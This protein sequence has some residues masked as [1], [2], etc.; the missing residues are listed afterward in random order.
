M[1]D[2]GGPLEPVAELRRAAESGYWTPLAVLGLGLVSILLLLTSNWLQERLV[3]QNSDR[4]RIV[5]DIQT[6]IATTHLWIEE[7]VTGDAVDM[8]GVLASF[9]R[10]VGSA[11]MLIAGGSLGEEARIAPLDDPRLRTLAQDLERRLEGFSRLTSARRDGYVRGESVGIG[12]AVDREYDRTF[13][14]VAGVAQELADGLHHHLAAQQRRLRLLANGIM[15]GWGLMVLLAALGLAS[16]ERRRRLTEEALRKSEER[17]LQAQKMEAVGRLAGGIAH[18]INNYLAAI[19]GQAELVKMKAEPGS[20]VA[21]KMDAVIT[22][23]FR[24]SDLI[25]RLLAFSRRQAVQPQ[26][27][28]LNEIVGGLERMMQQLIGEDI[29][30]ATCLSLDLWRVRV[31]PTQVEQVIVN[32]L[33]NAREAMPTGGKVTI[34]TGNVTKRR[35]DRVEGLPPAGDFVLL[36]VTDDGPGIPQAIR[37][38]IFEP[39]FTTKGDSGSS[40]LGLATV[41][42]I[43]EQAGGHLWVYSETGRG[44]TFKIYLPRCHE[45][46][47]ELAAAVREQ[48]AARGTESLLLVEDHLDLRHSIKEVLHELGYQVTTAVDGE[49]A[50]FRLARAGEGE[51]PF[52]LVVTDVVMP[53]LSGRDLRDRLHREWPEVPVLFVSGYT[54]NVVLRHGILAGEV[55]FLQKPF[56]AEQLAQKIR[57]VLARKAEA[58]AVPG[59]IR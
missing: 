22:T 57:E 34:E 54:D 14:E 38:K 15:V 16:K 37:N 36:T 48:A 45:A 49:D 58:V 27:M 2:H 18:D 51:R 33:V 17:L 55:D 3:V 26:V 35:E 31:D 44:T 50:L 6:S 21:E 41:Y 9:G 1:S 59:P 29:E 10:A 32:L 40:G 28:D 11:R 39:F 13:L 23:S 52:D 25:K 47:P 42:G 19:T 56:S 43:V 46:R 24:A 8:D 4:A 20:R 53:G 7:F 30:L 5:S 12:S